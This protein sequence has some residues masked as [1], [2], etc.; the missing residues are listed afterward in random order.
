MLGN[1][2]VRISRAE[3]KKMSQ[4]KTFCPKGLFSYQEFT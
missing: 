1:T 3:R 4:G 2:D